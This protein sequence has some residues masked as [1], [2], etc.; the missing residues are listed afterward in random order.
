ME[1]Y[2]YRP[3]DLEECSFRLIH[4]PKRDGGPLRCEIFHTDLR[5]AENGMEYEALSYTWGDLHKS[6]ELEVNG[7]TLPIT[8]N[9]H[10]ALQHLQNPHEDRIL[11]IDALCI[12]QENIEE[13]GHQVRNMA[14]IYENAIRVI[15]W[16]GQSTADIDI[17]FR[18]MNQLEKQALRHAC[19]NWD[20]S[21][22][23]WELLWYN[24]EL[25]LQDTHEK[26]RALEGSVE[27]AARPWFKRAWI[28]QEIAKARSARVMCG[29]QSVSARIFAVT[30]V[31]SQRLSDSHVRA[32][33]DI[34]PGPSRKSSWW[35][36]RRD[37]RTLLQKFKKSEATDPRD[38]IYA[39]LGICS[40]AHEP[41][42][43]I[44]DY[45]KRPREVILD[46]VAHLLRLQ[47]I[48]ISEKVLPFCVELEELLDTLILIGETI[49]DEAVLEDW[50]EV[51]E[52]LLWSFD[53]NVNPILLW[54]AKEGC[55]TIVELL[56]KRSGTEIDAKDGSI[57]TPLSLAARYGHKAI[58]KLLLDTGEVEVNSKDIHK[59]FTPLSWAVYNGHKDVVKLLLSEEQV[60]VNSVDRLGRTPLAVASEKG[61]KAVVHMLLSAANIE[62]YHRDNNGQTPLSLAA[63]YGRE[64]TVDLLL[65]MNQAYV[66]PEDYFLSTPL[67]WAEKNEHE[68]VIRL[69]QSYRQSLK[70]EI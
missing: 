1:L 7:K 51:A 50:L 58:V 48:T 4:L 46:T 59:G 40:D 38:S 20:A 66:D 64:S 61:H 57:S 49:L 31:F 34:M 60:D 41:S 33:L 25:E 12:D 63:Q 67:L 68:G 18:Y 26:S 13:R 53:T 69:L 65:N 21:D 62:V 24:V 43:P 45:K 16:L 19:N 42:F 44:P 37:L 30:P 28:I 14:S 10:L 5:D 32:I 29:T 2:T 6:H 54:A 23:R 47:D 9:L 27:L 36:E 39:L 11:W 17:F 52:M 56:L 3:I 55:A 22:T 15:I 35:N 8:R 70:Q